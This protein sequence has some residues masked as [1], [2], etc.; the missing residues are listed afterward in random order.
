MTQSPICQRCFWG[1]CFPSSNFS[2]CLNSEEATH[3]YFRKKGISK[4]PKSL[5]NIVYLSSDTRFVGEKI[6]RYI[7]CIVHM[8]R[9][10]KINKNS[11]HGVLFTNLKFYSRA[12]L[13]WYQRLDW[14][15]VVSKPRLKRRRLWD[16]RVT[17]G[18]GCLNS[19]LL[20]F[21]FQNML[22]NCSLREGGSAARFWISKYSMRHCSPRQGFQS[23][24]HRF[25]LWDVFCW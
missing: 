3:S 5:P 13:Q 20:D 8:F 7:Q 24:R 11:Y 19:M 15:S 10:L 16:I 22:C 25:P 18:W 1:C 21:R 14:R 9:H 12:W 2:I 23:T 17:V 4:L 6:F